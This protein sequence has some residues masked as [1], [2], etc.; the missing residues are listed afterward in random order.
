MRKINNFNDTATSK[1]ILE[2]I[3][4]RAENIDGLRIMEVCGT[5]TMAAG[6]HGLRRLL[7]SNI[8]LISGP[9]CPVCV[10]PAD[11]IDNAV[12]TATRNLCTVATYGDMLRVPGHMTSLE[13]ARAEGLPVKII[14]SPADILN[15][16]GK[17]LF[18]AV[19][20]ETTTAPIAAIVDSV[21][22]Q[23]LNNI[24]FYTSIKTVP[25][26][27]YLLMEDPEIDVNAFL[28]PGHVSVIIG[29][30]AYGDLPIPAAIAGFDSMDMLSAILEMIKMKEEGKSGV[31][32]RYT[33]VVSNK[34]NKK[35]LSLINKYFEESDQAWRGVGALVGC[36]LQLKEE[37][38]KIDAQKHF[39]ILPLS[40]VPS[41]GCSCGDILKGKIT[42]DECQLFDNG[43]DPENPM[44]PC[45][46]SSE[47]SCAA[48]YRY[49]RQS[50]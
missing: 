23:N 21:I 27:L 40:D 39:R 44:G 11:Y 34:G 42:P 48:Y 19:G 2:E 32:N 33:R 24:F 18:L 14:T 49:E 30:D 22:K 46:V 4:K 16:D 29:S 37:Y 15:I 12:K 8:K 35:A 3:N 36:S 31:I 47:G 17:V 41:F 28:L 43:C 13:K 20:F 50:S 26:T 7:P 38:S 6:K 10:T 45:M 1:L 9:G 25:K 5:H